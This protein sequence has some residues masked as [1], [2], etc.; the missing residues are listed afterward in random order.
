[1]GGERNTYVVLGEKTYR[2]K[3]GRARRRWEH[4]IKIYD[5]VMHLRLFFLW[6]PLIMGKE[7][8]ISIGY[9]DVFFPETVWI[10]E[11]RILSVPVG[12]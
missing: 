5:S 2:E 8:P 3:I 1:M 6:V 9:E 11:E 10:W 12:N 4:I 7:F